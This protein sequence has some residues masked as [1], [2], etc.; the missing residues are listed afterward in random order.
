[1]IVYLN[2]EYVP[3]AGA[4]VSVDDRGFLFG[5]GV[6]EVVR[7]YAGRSFLMEDHLRR[8]AAGLSALR[9]ELQDPAGLGAAAERLLD[10][11]G[12]RAGESVVYI[13]VT[14]GSA[15]RMHAFP[16]PE[17]PPTVYVA[18]R[19]FREH[20]ASYY[21][22]GV[23]AITLPD[24]RWARCDIK[25][26]ALLPNV[27]ANQQAKEA[28]AFEALLVRDGIVLEGSHSNVFA[29]ADGVLVT[30][31]ASNYI[32]P[33]ITRRVVLK[34][35]AEQSV[36]AREGLIPLEGLFEVDELFLAGTTTEVMPVVLV[37]G[38]PIGGGR[39]GPVTTE[40][41]RL[42]RARSRPRAAVR[43]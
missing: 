20:P 11:N 41:L 18:A 33:G 7:V 16:G 28:G 21:E 38:R 30:Y 2:G 23:S 39:P 40:L 13:Q 36:P 9:I 5:D 43:A 6:Y 17:V 10:E 37:D 1:M 26:I 24:N 29:V 14:R 12:L 34:L 35:A 42:Y 4:R 25:S 31:P 27:L 8:L 3:H 19:P 22:D 15:P 32:L